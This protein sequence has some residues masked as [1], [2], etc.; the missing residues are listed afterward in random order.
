MSE[1]DREHLKQLAFDFTTKLIAYI[2][3]AVGAAPKPIEPAPA[4]PPYAKFTSFPPFETKQATLT[5]ETNVAGLEY[6]LVADDDKNSWYDDTR[7]PLPDN[8]TITVQARA[9]GDFVKVFDAGFTVSVDSLPFKWE[10][11]ASGDVTPLPAEPKSATAAVNA[12]LDGHAGGYNVEREIWNEFSQDEWNYLYKQVPAPVVRGF[13]AWRP[14]DGIFAGNGGKSDAMPRD[15][16]IASFVEGAVRARK[17]GFK[18]VIVDASDVCTDGSFSGD[19][20]MLIQRTAV[21]LCE[22]IK[23]RQLPPDFIAVGP[24]NEWATSQSNVHKYQ[25]QFF[26]AMERVLPQHVLVFGCDYWK[27][28]G[29]LIENTNFQPPRQERAFCDTHSYTTMD[30]NGWKWLAGE[31]SKWQQRTKRRVIYGEAGLGT[32][33]RDE[34]QPHLYPDNAR[35][36][37]PIMRP[38]CPL[39]WSVNKGGHWRLNANGA[40]FTHP[41][42]WHTAPDIVGALND[43]LGLR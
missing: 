17:A 11:D 30:A 34:Q 5:V 23:K 9:T 38:F 2:D 13:I 40:E 37:L 24:V 33:M 21:A 25:Q 28:W 36:M 18:R 31:L 3:K 42:S 15:G 4:Q 41:K 12:F 8:K 7:K 43:G 27:Y 1:S 39:P 35:L 22:E 6:V 19:R 32:L 26:D 20:P 14:E 29:K 10:D 16:F